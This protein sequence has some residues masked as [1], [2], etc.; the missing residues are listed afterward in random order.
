LLLAGAPFQLIGCELQPARIPA[1][2]WTHR[3]RMAK[4][5]GGNTIAVYVFW[6]HHETTEG[7]F[8]FATGGRDLAYKARPVLAEI[9]AARKRHGGDA[10]GR[11]RTGCARCSS[12]SLSIRR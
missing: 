11:Y 7:R 1:E 2:Y 4:A 12:A 6:N 3:I 9:Q 8:D 5:L 10:D